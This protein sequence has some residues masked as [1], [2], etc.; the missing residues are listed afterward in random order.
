MAII[1]VKNSESGRTNMVVGQRIKKL[2]AGK[3]TNY[4]KNIGVAE[5]ML[6]AIASITEGDELLVTGETTGAYELVAHDLHDE[7]GNP[8]DAVLQGK[9][10]ALK[11]NKVVRRGDKLY[12]SVAQHG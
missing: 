5:F 12:K 7:Q 4:F 10:F 11:T 2:Y 8:A 3:C 9:L 6:E 1:R